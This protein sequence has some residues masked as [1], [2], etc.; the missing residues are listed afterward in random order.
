MSENLS[1][2]TPEDGENSSQFEG[3]FDDFD[4]SSLVTAEEH[5]A[6]KSQVEASYAERDADRQPAVDEA[7]SDIDALFEDSND[8]VVEAQEQE[9]PR[10]VLVNGE[11]V[12]V[13]ESYQDKSKSQNEWIVYRDS[14]GNE[15]HTMNFAEQPVE[16]DQPEVVADAAEAEPAQ[17]EEAVEEEQPSESDDAVQAALAHLEEVSQTKMPTEIAAENAVDPEA[18]VLSGPE[19]PEEPRETLED[20]SKEVQDESSPEGPK[21]EAA[22]QPEQQPEA[23]EKTAKTEAQEKQTDILQGTAKRLEETRRGLASLDRQQD[24]SI[25]DAINIL[26]SEISKLGQFDN[27]FTRFGDV[28][29]RLQGQLDQLEHHAEHAATVEKQKSEMIENT[30]MSLIRESQQASAPENAQEIAGRGERLLNAAKPSGERTSR[31]EEILRTTLR[32]IRNA[33][34]RNRGTNDVIGML[35]R[36]R[37]QLEGAKQNE[38]EK[39]Y[40]SRITGMIKRD[41][42]R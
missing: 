31:T 38:R 33:E 25:N 1:H 16:E 26:S 6:I 42:K 19:L 40:S 5:S 11:Q 20:L 27:N 36:F 41:M 24:R 30:K 28:T 4:I 14:D 32:E 39:G 17:A 2:H 29:R 3:S 21:Q 10:T 7:R 37:S 18:E 23:Q 15:K 22:Q 9:Q 34:L 35:Q 13:T 12:Q 8:T